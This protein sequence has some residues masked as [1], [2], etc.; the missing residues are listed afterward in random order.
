MNLSKY[1]ESLSIFQHDIARMSGY[2]LK[3]WLRNTFVI[4]DQDFNF[5]PHMSLE[6]DTMKR[7][8]QL[9]FALGFALAP[10]V[11][12]MAAQL[13]I[14]IDLSTFNGDD[15]VENTAVDQAGTLS[16]PNP[17][18]SQPNAPARIAGVNPLTGTPYLS[19]TMEQGAGSISGYTWYQQGIVA[20]P[21]DGFGP[22]P[23]PPVGS[24]LVQTPFLS[25]ATTGTPDTTFQF[26]PF[27]G[28]N[29][30]FLSQFSPSGDGPATLGLAT[31]AKY[32]SLSILTA[33][34]NGPKGLMVTYNY[35]NGTSVVEPI[36]NSPDWFG[37]SSALS[38]FNAGDRISDAGDGSF[39][40]DTQTNNPHFSQVDLA[41]PDS[42][43]ALS[44]ITFTAQSGGN[45]AIQGLS[46]QA[47]AVPEPASCF[48][49]LGGAGLMA[50]R[51]RRQAKVGGAA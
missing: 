11:S 41:A 26:A 32:S 38:A 33:T 29:V 40:F 14:G 4:C 22:K 2:I 16:M 8:K 36:V 48:L 37:G 7:T 34:A 50:L 30:L 47:A 31:P 9:A 42:T 45:V 28:P 12:A 5:Q 46:G 24:G 43:L 23:Q 15:V 6:G 1:N 13:P 3:R 39:N 10:V 18:A 19:A 51:R 21:A 49:L 20:A 27:T 17:N 44:S 35:A 25:T